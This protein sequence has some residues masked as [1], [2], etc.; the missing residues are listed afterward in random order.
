M[1]DPVRTDTKTLI[2]A[3]RI[4]SRE[5]HCKDGV[6]TAA[7]AEGAD[8]IEELLLTTAEVAVLNRAIGLIE[9]RAEEASCIHVAGYLIE[10]AETLRGIKKRLRCDGV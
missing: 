7:I 2:A 9:R 8:R 4:L 10:D 3:L 5:I 1:S 6:A